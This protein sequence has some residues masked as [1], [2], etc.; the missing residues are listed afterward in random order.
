MYQHLLVPLDDSMLSTVNTREAVRLA[1]AWRARITFF[2]ATEDYGATQ[3][4]ALLRSVAPEKFADAA[5]GDTY[6]LLQKARASAAAAGVRCDLKSSVSDRP[7]QA[8]VEAA[9]HHGCD[10]IVMASHGG[11]GLGNW[12]RRSHTEQVLRHAPVPVLVTRVESSEPLSARERALS[13]ILD[14]HRSI[15]SVIRGMRDLAA[16]AVAHGSA[17]DRRN[18]EGMLAYVREFPLR[19]HHP[20]E[21]LH[22][23]PK[24]R[25]RHPASELLLQEIELQ[26]GQEYRLVEQIG[27]LLLAMRQDG[28]GT[29]LV[30]DMAALLERLAG[31]V[32]THLRTEE[33]R[34]LPLASEH[35]LDEDWAEMAEAFE[36]NQDPN[37][38][39][40]SA[41]DFRRMFV[42]IANL[43]ASTGH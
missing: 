28:S 9:A 13:V 43:L 10:L 11:R 26:H 33:D 22:L 27:E 37:F 8:I 20:K 6:G 3:D 32:W 29:A 31:T 18:L 36:A 7:A 12:L 38:G 14:E 25:L 30:A 35:L 17:L 19:L 15:A 39:Q 42:R 4:G 21:E 2:H 1:A 24:L 5:V 16:E 41:A 34:V 40:L 23:H